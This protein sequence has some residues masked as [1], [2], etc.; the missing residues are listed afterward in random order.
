MLQV[1]RKFILE[2][3]V[4]DR[5]SPSTVS[6]RISSLD[7]ELRNDTVEDY[8]LV[9]TAAR[10]SH[11]VLHRFRGLLREKAKMHVS[12]RRMYRRTVRHRRRATLD[13]GCGG[14]NGLLF[15]RW[16]LIEDITVTR[17][18]IPVDGLDNLL[19]TELKDVLGFR[20]GEHVESLAFITSARKG[21][22]S[23]G[24]LR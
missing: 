22:V 11:E 16:P 4:P 6:Q 10:V 7:H 8:A 3:L 18:I 20:A 15:A 24:F 13:R 2:L 23:S 1:I 14:S 19:F 21:G 5:C 12:E 17:L 9:V